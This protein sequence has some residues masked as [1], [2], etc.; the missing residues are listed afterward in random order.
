MY[1]VELVREFSIVSF[2]V[3]GVIPLS[4]IAVSLMY[5]CRG[6]PYIVMESIAVFPVISV[7]VAV[8][9]FWPCIMGILFIVN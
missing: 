6:S 2:V 8:I 7:N 3:S 1:P 9:V 5:C 4:G